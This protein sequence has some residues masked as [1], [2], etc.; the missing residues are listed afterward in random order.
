MIFTPTQNWHPPKVRPAREP[1]TPLVPTSFSPSVPP[2][3]IPYSLLP[4]PCL[5]VPRFLVKLP[6]QRISSKPLKTRRNLLALTW[7]LITAIRYHQT[8]LRETGKFRRTPASI[9]RLYSRRRWVLPSPAPCEFR[10]HRE[11]CDK[12]TVTGE[13]R[14]PNCA[15][16]PKNGCLQTAQNVNHRSSGGLFASPAR[17]SVWKRHFPGVGFWL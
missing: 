17:K 9:A 12:E 16:S 2:F 14:T 1:S 10:R 4:I 7:R 15:L 6:A 11:S 13:L 8:M 3:P 5:S